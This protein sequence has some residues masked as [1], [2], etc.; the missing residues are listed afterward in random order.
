[1]SRVRRLPPAA[2]T[3]L[4]I[5]GF[6][7]A[8]LAITYP[9]TRGITTHLPND[10]VDPVLNT[11][12]LAWDATRI[13]HGLVG[14]WDPPSFFPYPR[15]LAYSDHLLGIAFFTAPIQWLTDN[16]VLVYNLAFLGSFVH[17]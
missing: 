13:R 14:L 10:L 11:W 7:L 6:T 2:E 12:I 4:V 15:T 5:S 1:M 3:T 8:V 16:P 9:L 17:A